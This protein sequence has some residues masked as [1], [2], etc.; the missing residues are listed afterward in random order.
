[1]AKK[2]K[3]GASA[4][5]NGDATQAAGGGPGA[6]ARPTGSPAPTGAGLYAIFDDR[7]KQYRA[8]EGALVRIDLKDAEPG[9][10]LTFDRV[11]LVG[12]ETAQV[13]AP[14]VP[15]ASVVAVV[16][17]EEKGKKVRGLRRRHHARSKTSWGHRQKY[18][19]VRVTK[20]VQ[21]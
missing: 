12:G 19:V 18:T 6:L 17:A 13:G 1:M 2:T 15:G 11:L 3:A 14:T 10:E 20:I 7:G 5:D 9:A 16:E 4:T 8:R 21:G